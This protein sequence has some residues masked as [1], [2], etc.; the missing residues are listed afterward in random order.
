MVRRTPQSFGIS[1][2]N[3]ISR[4]QTR[5]SG[6]G[7]GIGGVGGKR[8]RALMTHF[9]G[10]AKEC[11]HRRP[12]ERAADADALRADRRELAG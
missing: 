9:V 11:A 6:Q 8:E 3:G 5:T 2:G 12:I 4:G 7:R 1:A 10:G